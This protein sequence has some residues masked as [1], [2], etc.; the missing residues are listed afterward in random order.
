[1]K[2]GKKWKE[3]KEVQTLTIENLQDRRKWYKTNI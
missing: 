2:G 1:M 3:K